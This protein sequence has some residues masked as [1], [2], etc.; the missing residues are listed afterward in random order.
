MNA[1][2]RRLATRRAEPDSTRGD[3]GFG[4]IEIVISM[5]LLAI[6]A[7]ALIPVLVQGLQQAVSNATLASAT[8]LAN[9]KIEQARSWKTCTDVAASNT[10]VTEAHGVVLTID[11]TVG[12]CAP[13]AEN[14]VSVPVTVVVTRG[15]TGVIVTTTRTLVFIIAVIAEPEDD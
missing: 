3:E 4:L 2:H 5:M 7:T 9:E 15:D 13:S 10:S 11:T 14:P 6:L 1:I 12:S 8:Q